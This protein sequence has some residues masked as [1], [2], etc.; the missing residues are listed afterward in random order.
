MKKENKDINRFKEGE[1]FNNKQVNR[2]TFLSF[3]TF[4]AGSIAALLGWEWLYHE[5]LEKESVTAGTR[6]TLRGILNTNEQV[7]SKTLPGQHLAKTYPVAQAAK[8]PRVNGDVGLNNKNDIENW[9]LNVRLEGKTR[10]LSIEDIRKMPKTEHVVDFKC[11]EGWDQVMHW[12]GV[13]F[14]DFLKQAGLETYA[15]YKYAGLV[16]PDKQYYVG[17][18]MASMLHPQTLLAY[19]MN[20]QQITPEHGAPLRLI[21]PVKYGIKNLKRIGTLFFSN[22][23][24]PDYWAER[25]YDY[26]SGL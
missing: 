21:I 25:G 19:E 3:L 24:P 13:K 17:I 4:G 20:G 5:P 22:E 1:P 10:A 15:D 12:G 6:K 26:Y 2:R 14:S 11:V 23:R 9:K 8:S 18:D 16:T 7:F